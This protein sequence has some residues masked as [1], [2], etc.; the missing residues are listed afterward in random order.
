MSVWHILRI[1]WS[2]YPSVLAGCLALLLNYALATGATPGGLARSSRFWLFALGDLVLMLALV[3]PLDT[4]GDTYLF[5]VHMLQHLLLIQVVPPLLVLGLPA[6]LVDRALRRPAARRVERVL[7]Q[8]LLAWSLGIGTLWVWHLPAL[9]D[10][11]LA[12]EGVH[13]VQHLCF[14]LTSTIFWW[15]VLTPQSGRRLGLP[16][17]ILYLLGASFSSSVLGILIAFAPA[18]LYTGYLHPIDTLGILHV[19]RHDWGID[20]ASDQQIGGL[21]MWIPGGIAYLV[22]IIGVFGHWQSQPDWYDEPEGPRYPELLHESPR[23]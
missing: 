16:L 22:A 18:G 10:A 14:L 20:A 13:I 15:P 11:A 1:G 7:G 6:D 21:L 8:P 17:A 5:S 9:Y 3:S 19:I 2:P 23:R 12:S 4:L